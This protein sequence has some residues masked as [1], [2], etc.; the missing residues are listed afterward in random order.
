[1]CPCP[2]AHD[3]PTPIPTAFH[4]HNA[5][6]FV[7]PSQSSLIKLVAGP[8]TATHMGLYCLAAFLALGPLAIGRPIYKPPMVSKG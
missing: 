8:K 1:M 6:P 5:L 3:P 7:R 4:Q 2:L